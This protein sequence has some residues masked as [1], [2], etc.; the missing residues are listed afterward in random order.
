MQQKV[1][2]DG[3]VSAAI[4]ESSITVHEPGKEKRKGAYILCLIKQR[5]ALY[6]IRNLLR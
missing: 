6:I 4:C 5:Q 3:L 2:A 1:A